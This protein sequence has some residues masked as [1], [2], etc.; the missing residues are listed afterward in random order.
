METRSANA[1]S[2]ASARVG[3]CVSSED[4]GNEE[5]S[6]LNIVSSLT[7]LASLATGSQAEPSESLTRGWTLWRN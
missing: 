1:A 2:E 3:V 5:R 7:R 6:D 4:S